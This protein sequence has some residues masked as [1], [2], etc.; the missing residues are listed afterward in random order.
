MFKIE[1]FEKDVF[2]VFK[3]KIALGVLVIQYLFQLKLISRKI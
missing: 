1:A 3:K 2:N